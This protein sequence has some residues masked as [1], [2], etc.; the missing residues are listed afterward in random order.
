MITDLT[1][2][3]HFNITNLWFRRKFPTFCCCA[4]FSFVLAEKMSESKVNK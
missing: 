4:L 1:A 2:I 3:G